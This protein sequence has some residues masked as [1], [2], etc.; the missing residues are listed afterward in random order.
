ME[1]ILFCNIAYMQY[2]DFEIIRE[3]PKHGGLYVLETGDALEKMN[4]HV[5]GDSKVRGF[6]ETK[7][8]DSYV[9]GKKPSQLRIEHIDS[10]YIK[11]EKIDGVTVVF[12]AHSDIQKKS[13]IVGWYKNATV[14]R[15]RCLYKGRQFNIECN[16][17]DAFLLDENKRNFIIP[18]ATKDGI[19][20]GQSNLWYA[21]DEKSAAFVQTVLE[22]IETESSNELLQEET[23]PQVIPEEYK[24]NGIGEKVLVNK[25]ERNPVARRKCIELYGTKC[26]ICGFDSAKVYGDEFKDKIEVHHIVPINEVKK[27][28][29]V[30]PEKDLIPVCPNCHTMLHSKMS[31]GKMPTIDE[32]R[33]LIKKK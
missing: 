32:L 2:Y 11:S 14:F 4:F 31:N 10:G 6:V 17:S 24:E 33:K 25:Y 13:V 1:H 15:N 3:T 18:R 16:M 12:C 19:G 30:D 20:F 5:C 22:Y 28:Y 29:K 26:A 7:Y 8:R 21:K 9:S 27:E 23:N